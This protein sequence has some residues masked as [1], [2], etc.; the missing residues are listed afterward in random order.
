MSDMNPMPGS[1]ASRLMRRRR[2]LIDVGMGVTGMALQGLFAQEAQ[3][4]DAPRLPPKVDQVIWL[5]MAGG[6]SHTEGFDP[7]PALT[8]YGGHTIGATPYRDSLAADRLARR[9]IGPDLKY[10][11]RILPLQ[12][13]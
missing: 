4:D 13:G 10:D 6:V 1:S 12:I 2:F 9:E 3:A 5:F 11:T 7:K 8:R